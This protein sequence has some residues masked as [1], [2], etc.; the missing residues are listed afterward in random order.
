MQFPRQ[1]KSQQSYIFST[2]AVHSRMLKDSVGLGFS[3][4][5]AVIADQQILYSNPP[6]KFVTAD[7]QIKRRSN[8]NIFVRFPIHKF[9]T[10]IPGER[11]SL[12]HRPIDRIQ[13]ALQPLERNIQLSLGVVGVKI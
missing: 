12:F 11:N 4:I 13:L 9:F 5:T 2:I 1:K 7:K 10:V 3:R 8:R 6:P